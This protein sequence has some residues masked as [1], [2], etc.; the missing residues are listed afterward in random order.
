MER[1]SEAIRCRFYSPKDLAIA[2]QYRYG[3]RVHR[4]ILTLLAYA[5]F[6]A[7]GLPDTVLGV[8]WPQLRAAFQLP[9]SAM[10]TVL[11]AGTCG[12]FCSGLLA[13]AL[14]SR[15]G[16]GGVLTVSSGLVSLSLLGYAAAPSWTLFFPVGVVVGLG[17]GAVDASLNEYAARHFSARSLNWLHACWGVGAS[18][19]PTIMTAAIVHGRGYRG[20]YTYIAAGLATMTL[21]FAVTRRWWNDDANAPALCHD[22]RNRSRPSDTDHDAPTQSSQGDARKDATVQ[23]QPRDTRRD[24]PTQS[25]PGAVDALRNRSVWLLIL[26]FLLYTGFEASVGQWCFTWMRD[27]QGLD[28]AL[29]GYLTAAYW[30][31]LTVG[32]FVLGAF[33]GRVGPERLLR[34]CGIGVVLSVALF[35]ATTGLPSRIGLLALGLALAPFFPTLMSQTP[36]RV[37]ADL[38]RYS[39]GFQVSAATL[40]ASLAPAT[41]GLLVSSAGSTVIGTAILVLGMAFAAAHELLN[42]LARGQ[43]RA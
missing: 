27:V 40:G 15:L 33:V 42:A 4:W 1:S 36:A 16:I 30:A 17:S 43:V 28:T 19:G 9:P 34:L 32:R 11:V 24:A 37:G 35:A 12:Y 7:L 8:A 2:C 14:T 26:V 20:G 10:G 13:G 29:A 23:S 22:A 38:A 6:V 3:P 39:V 31:S 25:R 21:A 41:I 5:A 18:L